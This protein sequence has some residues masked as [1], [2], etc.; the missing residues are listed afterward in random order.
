RVLLD[1]GFAF[2]EANFGVAAFQEPQV[3]IAGDIDETLHRAVVAPVVDQ[4]RRR[5]FVP[6]PGIVWMILE[7]SLDLTGGHI[8][9]DGR[10]GVEIV[11]GPLVSHPRASVARTPVSQVGFWIVVSSDPHRT[12]TCFPVVAAL[13][14]RLAAGLSR[15][16]DSI[17]P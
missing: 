7:V 1:V 3:P 13:R 14:P 12:T 6:I 10:R 9:R 5:D 4:N 2:D 15:S 17:G 8:D 11:A 16:G